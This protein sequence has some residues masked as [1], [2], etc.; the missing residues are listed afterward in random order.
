MSHCVHK[1]VMLCGIQWVQLMFTLVD[2]MGSVD[3]YI[4]GSDTIQ[5][6]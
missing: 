1:R 6:S 4:S 3:V 2:Q 5:S